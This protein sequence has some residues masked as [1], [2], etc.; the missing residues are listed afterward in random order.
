MLRHLA[1]VRGIAAIVEGGEIRLQPRALLPEL[2][3]RGLDGLHLLAFGCEIA[4][5]AVLLAPLGLSVVARLGLSVMARLRRDW[6]GGGAGTLFEP[7][8]IVLEIAVEVAH[9]A[10]GHQPELVADAAQKAAIV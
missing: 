2:G 1:R 9:R 4:L 5:L 10:V 7:A 8:G 3:E 6:R